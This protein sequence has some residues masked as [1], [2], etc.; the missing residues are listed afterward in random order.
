MPFS[1]S[2]ITVSDTADKV[3][4]LSW[5]YTNDDG[6]ISSQWVLAQPYGDTPLKDC[7]ESV[8]VSWLEEQLPDT[9][10]TEFDKRIADAKAS[11]EFSETLK[12]YTPHNDGPPTPVTQEIVVPDLPETADV[13][14]PA[15]ADL[16]PKKRKK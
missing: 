12:P 7:T 5:V 13:Q 8:L 16:K 15:T 11:Q 1:V 2:E 4:A 10:V 9:A 3:V 14:S 6:E